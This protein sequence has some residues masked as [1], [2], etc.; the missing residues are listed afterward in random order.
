M[1]KRVIAWFS[2][3]VT[4]AIACFWAVHRYKNV[5]IVF[6]DTKRNEDEDTYRFMDDCKRLLYNG[7]EIVWLSN[8]NYNSIEEIW[9]KYSTLTTAHGALC[10]TELKREMREAYQDTEN[11][12]AQ[13]FGF[14]S[15]KKESNRHKQMRLNY[16]EINV[17]SPLD[18]FGYSKEYCIALLE[19]FGI[20]VP[21]AY[22]IGLENNN[23]LKT[24][25]VRG[26]I[27]YW[28]LFGS[29]FP[30]R[31]DSMA[32]REHHYTNIQGKPVTICKDQG[33]EAKEIGGYVPVFLRHHPDYPNVK[34]ISMIKGRQPKALM[35]CHGFCG[36][37]N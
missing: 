8:P 30:D 37:I 25:C 35:E 26:G 11:D 4:S 33:K 17:I 15:R 1:N 18:A 6:Q 2:G 29:L 16:P 28:K 32:D 7:Q 10:S 36:T 24:G 9:D 12:F 31:F 5:V 13:I 22:Y 27:G 23:C 14:D 21:L 19:G 20:R 3:G 34:D